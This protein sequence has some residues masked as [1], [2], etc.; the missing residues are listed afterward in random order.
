MLFAQKQIWAKRREQCVSVCFDLKRKNYNRNDSLSVW[1]SIWLF[2]YFIGFHPCT[3]RVCS[4]GLGVFPEIF[5]LR[6][7]RLA[8]IHATLL[9]HK[10]THSFSRSPRPLYICAFRINSIISKLML[11][12]VCILCV[13]VMFCCVHE[14]M[15]RFNLIM[16]EQWS[17]KNGDTRTQAG[18][19]RAREKIER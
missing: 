1:L 9:P 19:E 6:S 10:H 17:K 12:N 13:C 14:F 4:I 18:L 15:S 8:C 7:D 3:L 11:F 5:I 2:H 16:L